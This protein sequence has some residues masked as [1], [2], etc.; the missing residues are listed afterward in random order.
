LL[1]FQQAKFK[2]CSHLG[3]FNGCQEYNK[4]TPTEEMRAGGPTDFERNVNFTGERGEYTSGLMG[5]EI[6]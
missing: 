1:Q 3:K 5:K 6:D 4:M 2:L